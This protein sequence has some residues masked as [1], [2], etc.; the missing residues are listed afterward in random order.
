MN[1]R[2]FVAFVFVLCWATA[3]VAAGEY[4]TVE[5]ERLK[6]TIDSEW[7][8]EG[9]PGYYP[10]RFDIANLG[11]ARDID[12]VGRGSRWFASMGFNEGAIEVR[13]SL[14]LKKG[15]RVHLTIPV[16]LSGV[17]ENVQFQ[18]REGSR[19]LES[20]NYIGFVTKTGFTP[21]LIVADSTS[22]IGAAASS[23]VRSGSGAVYSALT[24]V[25]PGSAVTPVPPRGV[26]GTGGRPQLDFILDPVRLPTNWLSFT[27][28]AAVVIGPK[29]WEQLDPTQ[30][31]AL[32]TWTACGGSLM[33][34]D[35][36]LKMLRPGIGED[37]TS[38]SGAS[39]FLG[40]ISFPTAADITAGGLE[41]TLSLVN[42]QVKEP[43]LA[44]PA[45]RSP[46]WGQIKERGFQLPIPGV[47]GVPARAYFWILIFFTVLIWPANYLFLF[48]RRQQTF[49]V[50][51]VP[52]ISGL[53][54]AVLAVYAIAGEGFGVRGR[55]VTFTMLDQIGKEAATRAS[56][57]LYAAGMTPAGG[58]RFSRDVAVMPVGTDGQG[59]R[60]PEMINLTEAQQFSSGII[61]ARVPANIEE[62][63]FRPARERLS[64]TSDGGHISVLNGLGVKIT[65]LYYRDK[66]N[67]YTLNEPL[68]AGEK[69]A[70]Q[71]AEAN[72]ASAL[73]RSLV[74]SGVPSPEI[75]QRALNNHTNGS[76]IAVLERSPFWEPGVPNVDER[77]SFHFL[78]GFVGAEP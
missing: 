24:I 78:I 7:A 8:P 2:G 68:Q 47:N 29:E 45:N 11:D 49:L 15:D 26:R 40:H 37:V 16:P 30:K 69:R 44:L 58:L 39:Y 22:P 5:T 61:R 52:L 76:Y 41:A 54:V 21:V 42:S 62:L 25:T 74:Q 18:I 12:I 3:G 65:S 50:L 35:G 36:N 10:V 32:L 28:L 38:A 67:L 23:W 27:S 64:F 34:V 77:G 55:A 1:H 43:A 14:S 72:P 70:L 9:A 13:Q 71:G 66:G 51:T 48:R 33:F 19:I 46:N 4:R 73:L 17:N 63:A 31:G 59:S 75:F 60:E 56:I 20:F 53:F 6:I 57:S